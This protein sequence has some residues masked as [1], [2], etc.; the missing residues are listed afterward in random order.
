[1]VIDTDN[2]HG[3]LS[4]NDVLE[5]MCQGLWH[6]VGETVYYDEKLHLTEKIFKP[7][8]A[9]RPFILA[10]APG[11]LAYFKSYGFQTFD[12]WIDESYDSESDPVRRMDMIVAELSRLCRLSP[13]EL[14]AMY[15]EMSEVLE[16]NFNWLY[17]GFRKVLVDEMVDNF[18]RC[19]IQHNAGRNAGSVNYIDHSRM[20]WADIKM[21][22]TY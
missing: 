15:T 21:R 20:D 19:V 3:A 16:Y 11:N 7:I 1:L 22:L 5:T 2:H 10:G 14:D 13:A 12:R 18:R 17:G 8:V 4:A 6:I 9:K